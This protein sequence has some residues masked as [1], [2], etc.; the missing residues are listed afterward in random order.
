MLMRP[1]NP[2]DAHI[3]Q[4]P[5]RLRDVPDGFLIFLVELGV[6]EPKSPFVGLLQTCKS[7]LENLYELIDDLRKNEVD[8]Y[9]TPR[10][11]STT[12]LCE[13]FKGQESPFV[14]FSL[15]EN[16]RTDG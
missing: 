8:D 11:P 1:K 9:D 6:L 13:I 10:L 16:G 14:G 7:V 4:T 3:Y 12:E 2:A 15:L 5:K